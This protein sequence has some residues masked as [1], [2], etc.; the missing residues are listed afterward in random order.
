MRAHDR[1][2]PIVC[3]GLYAVAVFLHGQIVC[4]RCGEPV[5]TFHARDV[6]QGLRDDGKTV[7]GALIRS[8]R[9]E[10]ANG[11]APPA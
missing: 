10:A 5:L 2:A 4:A 8:L 7:T 6:F 3:D 1:E 11:S 9:A